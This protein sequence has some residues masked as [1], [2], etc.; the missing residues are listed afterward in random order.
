MRI[1]AAEKC[2]FTQKSSVAMIIERNKYLNVLLDNRHNGLV[3][4]VTGIRRSGKSFLLFNIFKH[5]LMEEG[6]DQQHIS[7]IYLNATR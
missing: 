7:L 1:F 6:V 2:V 4:I 3:K 5:R